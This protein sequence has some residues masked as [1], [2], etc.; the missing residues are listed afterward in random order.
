MN[1]CEPFELL[2]SLVIDDEATLEERA[3]LE[4]HLETCPD[5]RAYFEDLR[6]IHGTFAREDASLPEGFAARVMY[7]VRET[8]QELPEEEKAGKAERES[9]KTVPFPRW[10]R[11]AALAA[12]CALAA[13]SLWTLRGT[14]GV[15]DAKV[16]AD[17]ASPQLASLDIAAAD[18]GAP[19]READAL[20]EDSE[21]SAAV[22]DGAPD[23]NP[24]ALPEESVGIAKSAAKDGAAEGA[25]QPV[26][27]PQ[28]APEVAAGTL[29]GPV[30]NGGDTASEPG[31]SQFGN[32]LTDQTAPAL[33]EGKD[34]LTE[35]APESPA[36][37]PEVTAEAPEVPADAP[38]SPEEAP[39]ETPEAPEDTPE[40][41]AE[42][43]A[44]AE[45]I[46][47]P[48]PGILIAYG[49]A[50]RNWVETVLG[51]EWADGG[52]YP[53]T[54]EQYG[55]LLQALNESGETYRIEPGEGYCLMTE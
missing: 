10:R 32:E 2:A 44:P 42:N 5:C 6:R 12:C 25:Y 13:V 27:A 28:A 41:P 20:Y 24:P 37:A 48:E 55:G 4:E 23:E 19:V 36:D 35:E 33:R 34:L 51:L 52:S 46:G 45:I 31:G 47:V 1:C 11:W 8:P 7:R 3:K 30:E 21:D 17:N 38:E 29:P 43:V 18:G 16:T 49:A 40:A 39:A 54:A 9:K 14:G 15:R 53:L 50:A 22:K 26:P